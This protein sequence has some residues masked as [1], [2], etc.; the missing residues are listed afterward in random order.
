MKLRTINEPSPAR[1]GKTTHVILY[2]VC[3]DERFNCTYRY[4]RR[5]GGD[6][7]ISNDI[8]EKLRCDTPSRGGRHT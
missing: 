8:I 2:F 7:A 4:Q 6:D 1:G 3:K 5:G